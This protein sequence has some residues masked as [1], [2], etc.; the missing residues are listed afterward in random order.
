[1]SPNLA[2]LAG[3]LPQAL[4]RAERARVQRPEEL[5]AALEGPA[6][7]RLGLLQLLPR[8][9]RPSHLSRQDEA[10]QEFCRVTFRVL[11][12]VLDGAHM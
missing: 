2:M 1:M 6:E 10:A 4:E 3:D 11:L 9:P 5:L 12:G 8:P 7:E